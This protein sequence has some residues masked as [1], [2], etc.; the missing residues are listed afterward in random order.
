MFRML[1]IFIALGFIIY[2]VDKFKK[3][4]H[5]IDRA[6][7][8]KISTGI[9]LALCVLLVIM[10]RAHWVA[11]LAAGI[12]ALMQRALPLLIRFFPLLH[13]QYR[14]HQTGK[15]HEANQSEIR[16]DILLMTLDHDNGQLDGEILIGAFKDKHLSELEKE[17]LEQLYEYCMQQDEESVQL[18][19][20]YM[21]KRFEGEWDSHR[22]HE[23]Q[24]QYS[25]SDNASRPNSGD[26]SR[27]EALSILA[28]EDGA[29]DDEIIQAHRKLIQKLHPDR[30][31]SDYL[32]AKVNEAKQVLI[33]KS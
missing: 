2:G 7:I 6:L 5:K 13:Q 17:Q 15:M 16:T 28:L 4:K 32:A 3:N 8:L 26:M 29:S 20:A 1:L 21:Q 25:D 33:S 9:L 23:G 19:D 30:G 14:K 22:Q 24:Q 10:G 12:F 11:A 18:L 31:G 27:H